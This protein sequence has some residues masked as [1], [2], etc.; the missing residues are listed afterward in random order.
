MKKASPIKKTTT[1]YNKKVIK[2]RSKKSKSTPSGGKF[3]HSDRIISALASR[4]VFNKEQRCEKKIIMGLAGILD[5]KIFGTTLLN[6]KKKN[7]TVNYEGQHVWLTSIGEANIDE[8]ALKVPQTNDAMQAKIRNELIK[9][10]KPRKIYD[11]L[12]DGQYHTRADLAATLDLPDNKSFGTY[13]SSLSKVT[14]RNS[15]NKKQFRL[16]N[17]CFPFGRPCSPDPSKAYQEIII[18]L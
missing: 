4:R 12:L 5:K 15:L 1:D 2:G 14:E 13:T 16:Q 8:D 6:M 7:G 10:D 17:M 11:L 3:R 18:E 9:G